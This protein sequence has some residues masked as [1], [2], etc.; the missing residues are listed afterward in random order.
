MNLTPYWD[1]RLRGAIKSFWSVRGNQSAHQGA[2]SG[3]RDTGNRAA[4]TGGK[5][6]DGFA[7][8]IRDYLIECGIQKDDI[9]YHQQVELPG[10]FRA[11]KKWDM[12]VIVNDQLIAAMEFKSQVGSFGNNFN[13]RAEE[14]L[15]SATDIWAAYREGAFSPSQ[16]PWLGYLMVLEETDKSLQ[17]VTVQQPHFQVFPEFHGACYAKRYEILMTK[18]VRERLYDNAALLLSRPDAAEDGEHLQPSEELDFSNFL[19]ALKGRVSMIAGAS[20]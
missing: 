15:G 16:R 5:Q 11:E 13:N 7:E 19:T 18:M 2:A 10:W 6:L 3:T 12:L 8:L 17:P 1:E 20:K 9:F 4:V 14:V